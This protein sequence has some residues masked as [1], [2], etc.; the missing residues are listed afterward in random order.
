VKLCKV[1]PR[2]ALWVFA[3]ALLLKAA[4]PLLA[5]ASA[6]AQGKSLGE[7]CSVYGMVLVAPAQT[8][9]GPRP[10]GAAVAHD[11]HCALQALTA[12]ALASPVTADPM[13]IAPRMLREALPT[14]PPSRVGDA[15]A[16]WVAR[17]RHGP[18]SFV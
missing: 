10:Y 16:L 15:C 12:L 1:S 13:R 17:L 3:A 7:V 8:D 5:S 2:W 6:Q 11:E 14:Q 9:D 18:P 4:M